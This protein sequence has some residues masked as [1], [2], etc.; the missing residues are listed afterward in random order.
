MKILEVTEVILSLE[1]F[2]SLSIL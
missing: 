1:I 2:F